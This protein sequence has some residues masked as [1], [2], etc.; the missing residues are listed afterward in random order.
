MQL[1]KPETLTCAQCTLFRF[2]YCQNASL[3]NQ[4]FTNKKGTC[5]YSSDLN[6]PLLPAPL[7]NCSDKYFATNK[8]EWL[9]FLP[10]GYN[11]DKCGSPTQLLNLTTNISTI[12]V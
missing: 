6:N 5:G 7:Y 3:S 11:S 1:I 8:A 4:Y 2:N 9:T 12:N 10:C